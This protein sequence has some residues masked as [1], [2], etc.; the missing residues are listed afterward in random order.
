MDNR[1]IF[2][3]E[4]IYNDYTLNIFTDASFSKNTGCYGVAVVIKDR[5]LEYNCRITSYS[6]V[7][8]SELK[9]ARTSPI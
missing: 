9:V 2:S 5:I 4:T 8:E 6:T 3:L 7:P 1:P